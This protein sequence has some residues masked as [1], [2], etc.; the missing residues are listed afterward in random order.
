MR[1]ILLLPLAVVLPLT[2]AL[3][4]PYLPGEVP[5]SSVEREHFDAV[6]VVQERGDGG[7]GPLLVRI[8]VIGDGADA[9]LDDAFRWLRENAGIQVVRDPD[10]APLFLTRLDLA[11]TSGRGTLGATVPEGMAAEVR[12]MRVG[13]CVVAHEILHFVGLKH[14]ADKGNIMYS[15]CSKDFLEKAT[16]EEAQLERLASVEAI[17]ATTP[18]GVLVWASR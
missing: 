9:D 2:G 6:G 7:E 4:D 5:F 13:S 14:V 15:H 11:A 16:I 3:G 18:S 1:A 17:R 10:G 8:D 12:D